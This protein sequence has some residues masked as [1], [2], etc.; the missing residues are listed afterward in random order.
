MEKLQG[1]TSRRAADVERAKRRD[2]RK[3]WA[4]AATETAACERCGKGSSLFFF[5][6]SSFFF[7]PLS[8]FLLFSL[9]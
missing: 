9:F 6:L 2:D 5:P 1:K 4:A 3:K 7:N 8:L